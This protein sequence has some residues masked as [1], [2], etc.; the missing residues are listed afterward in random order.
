MHPVLQYILGC[1][2][3]LLIGSISA[4]FVVL[5]GRLVNRKG[6]T[7]LEIVFSLSAIAGFALFA[8]GR[9]IESR[10]LSASSVLLWGWVVLPILLIPPILLWRLVGW[11]RR[12]IA[13]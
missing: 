7:R 9:S 11:L 8:V 10:A 5:V 13:G 6:G 3:A 1:L 2:G 4:V 12:Q